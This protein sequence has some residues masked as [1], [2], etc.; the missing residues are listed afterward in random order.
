MR[1]G[2]KSPPAGE[3][4][5]W[6]VALPADDRRGAARRALVAILADYLGDSGP[7]DAAAVELS[8]GE[9]GKPRLADA[10]ERLSF[11]LSH[12]GDLALVAVA[13]GGGAVGVDIERLRPRRNLVRLAGRW[14]PAADA[15]A[16]AGVGGAERESVFYAAWTRHEARVKCTG[17]GLSGPAPGPEVIARQLEIDPGYAAAV[18]AEGSPRIVLRGA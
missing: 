16:V 15:A 8:V 14:L 2:H 11:N 12:S 4:H 6:R 17:A 18:A 3:L 10:P 9:N 5:V 13:P 1:R 7:A